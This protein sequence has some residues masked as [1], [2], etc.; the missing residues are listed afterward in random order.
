MVTKLMQKIVKN[1]EN[2]NREINKLAE[3]NKILEGM[4][5]SN[6]KMII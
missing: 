5:Q 4:I 2:Q 1:A 3:R 6:H